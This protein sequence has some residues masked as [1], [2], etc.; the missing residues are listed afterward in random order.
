MKPPALH[1]LQGRRGRRVAAK[2]VQVAGAEAAAAARA[3]A[4]R[5]LAAVQVQRVRRVQAIGRR[6]LGRVRRRELE[7]RNR[8]DVSPESAYSRAGATPQK[9]CMLQGASG[10]GMH[11][12]KNTKMDRS[13]RCLTMPPRPAAHLRVMVQEG[14]VRAAAPHCRPL[15]SGWPRAVRLPLPQ[16]RQDAVQ[17][18]S[19]PAIW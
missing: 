2:G 18:L 7:N 12:S 19:S 9:L 5:R 17:P 16:L 14:G 1:L 13:H 3:L 4:R 15:V 11:T 6:P 10:A 8:A